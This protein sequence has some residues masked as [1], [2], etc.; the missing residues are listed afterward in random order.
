MKL[1]L[2]ILIPVLMAVAKALGIDNLTPDVVAM[3]VIVPVVTLLSMIVKPIGA[4]AVA[5]AVVAVGLGV[6]YALVRPPTPETTT[7]LRI[8]MGVANGLG[9]A[10][11][12]SVGKAVLESALPSRPTVVQ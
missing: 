6:A 12:W 8:I 3:G 10:G 4:S 11:L 5:K 1:I 9:A 2:T 7:A